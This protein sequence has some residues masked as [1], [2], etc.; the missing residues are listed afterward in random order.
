MAIRELELRKFTPEEYLAI[1]R[2]SVEKSQYLDGQIFD[3]DGNLR[4]FTTDEPFSIERDTDERSEYILGTLCNQ[5]RSTP[6]HNIITCNIMAALHGQFRGTPN[7]VFAGGIRISTAPG[8]LACPDATVVCGEVR[9]HNRRPDAITNPTVIIEVM[10]RI[11]AKDARGRRL[12]HYKRID[13]LTNYL[14]VAE[15][16][17]LIEQCYRQPDGE[18]NITVTEGL[19][20][21]VNVG[22]VGCV[23]K[24]ADV[25][26]RIEFGAGAE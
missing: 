20:R 3:M 7:L 10:P 22:S 14:L 2:A 13:S 16:R 24:L 6:E 11:R 1:D 19:T 8:L 25:Y 5:E 9:L 26:D 17:P 15:N 18:W 23:L 21:Q 4:R 12:D